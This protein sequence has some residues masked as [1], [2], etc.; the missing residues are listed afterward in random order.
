MN[1]YFITGVSRGIGKALVEE[2]LKNETNYVIGL[3]E[4]QL[5]SMSNMSL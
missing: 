3:A 2:L 4:H 1:Y 5:L